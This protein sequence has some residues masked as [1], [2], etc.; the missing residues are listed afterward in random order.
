M[1]DNIHE[2]QPY[3]RFKYPENCTTSY[4]LIEFQST[5]D[6]LLALRLM[7]DAD[8]LF[9]RLVSRSELSEGKFGSVFENIRRRIN[10]AYSR[11]T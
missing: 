2:R 11:Q 7:A 4:L 3:A 1:S 9:Q 8:L 6:R 10:D 5:V